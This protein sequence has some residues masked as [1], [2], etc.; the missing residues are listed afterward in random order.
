MDRTGPGRVRA[1][2]ARKPTRTEQRQRET[3]VRLRWAA[4]GLMAEG[5]VDATTIQQIT[6]RADIGFGTFYNYYATKEDLAIEVLDCVVHNLGERNDLVTNELGE[7][8]PVRI[9][10]NS[11]RLVVRELVTNPMWR[12]WLA[13]PDLL[14]ERIRIGFG[15]FGLRDIE[16]AV[17]AD[18]YHLI[19]D[20]VRLAWSQLNWLII[21]AAKDIVDGYAGDDDQSRYVEA[22]LRANGVGPDAARAA[23]AAPLPALPALDIDFTFELEA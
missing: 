16:Q 8:D 21:A 9:V 18:S 7:T 13:R 22:A 5:G 1:V 4:Y 19:N 11:V 20:D 12:W 3:R 2:S 6:D 15:P 23:C 14:I 10:A 17:G